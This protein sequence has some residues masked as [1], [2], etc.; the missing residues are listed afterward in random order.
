MHYKVPCTLMLSVFGFS[1]LD[2]FVKVLNV[3]N[4]QFLHE[5]FRSVCWLE[6]EMNSV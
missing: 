5:G 6:D 1:H 3:I 4:K 2:E